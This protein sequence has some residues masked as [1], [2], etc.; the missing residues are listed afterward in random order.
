MGRE[1]H[2]MQIKKASY[3]SAVSHLKVMRGWFKILGTTTEKVGKLRLKYNKVC[4]IDVL[5]CV[6]IFKRCRRLAKYDGFCV[7]RVDSLNLIR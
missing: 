7:D 5:S 3:R 4:E 1:N 6:E 2:T